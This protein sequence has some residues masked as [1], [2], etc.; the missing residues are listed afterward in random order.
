MGLAELA[1]WLHSYIHKA[2]KKTNSEGGSI[3]CILDHTY[4]TY[5]CVEPKSGDVK[6]ERCCSNP[7][8]HT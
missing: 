5:V 7:L 1:T 6:R 3:E 8:A 2:S 4:N